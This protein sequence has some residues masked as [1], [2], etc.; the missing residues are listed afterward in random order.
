M[1][2]S[3][4]SHLVWLMHPPLGQH[5]KHCQHTPVFR[6]TRS[7]SQR[8]NLLYLLISFIKWQK[9]SYCP[10]CCLQ[11]IISSKINLGTYILVQTVFVIVVFQITEAWYHH[12]SS[13]PCDII[14]HNM[15]LHYFI[16]ETFHK[17]SKQVSLT[18]QFK[19]KNLHLWIKILHKWVE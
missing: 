2:H 12:D 17:F 5:I 9:L 8:Q 10:W 7:S 18:L 3:C 15:R 19:N 4:H 6:N 16:L 13:F 1:S 11:F 14:Y